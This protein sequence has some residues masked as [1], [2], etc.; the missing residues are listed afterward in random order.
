MSAAR[1][2]G[3]AQS[4][5]CSVAMYERL[6]DHVAAMSVGQVRAALSAARQ[7]LASKGTEDVAAA[8]PECVDLLVTSVG[9]T[10]GEFCTGYALAR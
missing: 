4:S 2:F 10:L 7:Q 3:A 1:F 8:A 5:A 6:H 9:M